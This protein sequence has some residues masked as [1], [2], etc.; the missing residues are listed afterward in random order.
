[1][2]RKPTSLPN[3]REAARLAVA[4]GLTYKEAARLVG[5][6]DKEVL[7]AMREVP[8]DVFQEM[9]KT[10]SRALQ[11]RCYVK[12]MA[13]IDAIDEEDL[14][15]ST[16]V[17]NATAAAILI[18]KASDKLAPT[19]GIVKED[20]TSFDVEQIEKLTSNIMK[21]FESLKL[22]QIELSGAQ[23]SDAHAPPSDPLPP[24]EAVLPETPEIPTDPVQ[25]EDATGSD[26]HH[27]AS[28][29]GASPSGAAEPRSS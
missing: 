22:T 16:P 17:A 8:D 20:D 3:Q 9:V 10:M 2:A 25:S 4:H 26:T 7:K 28:G 21:R 19:T 24:G 1:M 6:A 14:K 29:D 5:I 18:D 15:E 12:A 27:R 11:M 13:A 23:S